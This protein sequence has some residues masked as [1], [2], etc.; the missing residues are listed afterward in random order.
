MRIRRV[1]VVAVSAGLVAAAA[2]NPAAAKMYKMHKKMCSNAMM[3]AC[4]MEKSGMKHPAWTSQCLAEKW[5]VKVV[6]P[7]P[8]KW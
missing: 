7:G 5:G 8:C 2:A 1:L 4:I 6:N 3:Q